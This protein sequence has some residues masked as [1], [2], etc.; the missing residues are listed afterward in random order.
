[1][2]EFSILT[3]LIGFLLGYYFKVIEELFRREKQNDTQD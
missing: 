1:M 2:N 3:F